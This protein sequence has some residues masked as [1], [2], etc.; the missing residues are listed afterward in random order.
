MN[1]QLDL[2]LD[3]RSVRF[4]NEVVA[5]LDARDAER[6]AAGLAAL[7]AH[8]PNDANLPALEFL[9]DALAGW[10]KPAA[11]A[12]A[13]AGAARWLEG[14]VA[15]AAQR[16][17]GACAGRFV[18]AFFRELA[19]VARGLSYSNA[20]PTA[21]RAW[22]CLRCGAWAEA[23]AAAQAIPRASTTPDALQWLACARYRQHGLAA[24]RSA[25]FALA[26]HAPP[27]LA[28]ALA[29]LQDEL[30]DRDWQRFAGACEWDS[31]PDA[32]LPAWFPAWYLHEHPAARS[33][34]DY[35]DAPNTKPAETA[36]LLNH[37]LDLESRGDWHKLASARDKLRN[38]NEDLFKLYMVRRAVQHL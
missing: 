11:D 24:A 35:F 36:R 15:P 9:T 2:F 12:Q 31:L 34:L 29:E 3:S 28:S 1:D 4:V 25:L 27:R 22:L 10:C 21:H 17:L 14:E 19:D 23:E 20:Q 38:L 5:A 7:R 6:A 16:A 18:C 26:W 13:I 8:A 37:I 32:E 33:D 30:L